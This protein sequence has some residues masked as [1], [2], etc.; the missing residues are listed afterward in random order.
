VDAICPETNEEI[1]YSVESL[2][3]EYINIQK[4][5]KSYESYKSHITIQIIQ[6]IYESY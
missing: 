4:V 2:K 6:I 5:D 1:D 3:A